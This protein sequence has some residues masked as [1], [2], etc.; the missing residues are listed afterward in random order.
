LGELTFISKGKGEPTF[1]HKAGDM[2]ATFHP[3]SLGTN[4]N[5]PFSGEVGE[6]KIREWGPHGMFMTSNYKR[7][8]LDTLRSSPDRIPSRNVMSVIQLSPTEIM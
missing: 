3:I 7:Y 4:D 1:A 6:G 5:L 2:E 8:D